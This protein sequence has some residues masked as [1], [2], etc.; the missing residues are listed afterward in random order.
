MAPTGIGS[1]GT[2]VM[3]LAQTLG[4]YIALAAFLREMR[5][6]VKTVPEEVH[7]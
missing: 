6:S 7:P 2:K 4:E 5:I 3:Q 1:R